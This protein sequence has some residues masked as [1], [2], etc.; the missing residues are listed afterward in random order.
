MR[1]ANN[2]GTQRTPETTTSGVLHYS[3]GMRTMN[4]MTIKEAAEYHGIHPQTIYHAVRDGRIKS[5]RFGDRVLVLDEQSV[6]TF[7]KRGRGR[8]RKSA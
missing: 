7:K 6:R 3:E 8:P 2:I 4:G 1:P 5:E